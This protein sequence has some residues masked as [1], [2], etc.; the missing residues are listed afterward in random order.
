[1]E[2]PT[3]SSAAPDDGGVRI[4][5]VGG[6][7]G[8]HITPGLEVVERLTQDGR[9]ASLTWLAGDRRVDRR[10]LDALPERLAPIPVRVES[11]GVEG[12]RDAAPSRGAQLR[13]LPRAVA[14]ARAVL[15][16]S[17]AELLIALGGYT[18]LPAALA[19]RSLGIPL[20]LVEVNSV[21]GGATKLLSPLAA[22]VCH[23]FDASVPGGSRTDDP[24]HRADTR[25]GVVGPIVRTRTEAECRSIEARA[26]ELLSKH[27]LAQ[28]APLL[29]VLGGSQGA[30]AL[31][32]FVREQI[33]LFRDC[34]LQVLH[35]VGPGRM[36]EAA[37]DREGYAAVEFLDPVDPALSAAT[38]VLSRAGAA[39]L[40]ELIA[41]RVPAILVPYPHAAGDHQAHNAAQVADGAVVIKE[42]LLDRERAEGIAML[43]GESGVDRRRR[44]ALELARHS[45]LDGAGEVARSALEL[46]DRDPESGPVRTPE[47]VPSRLEVV[48]SELEGD[49]LPS[50]LPNRVHLLG[51]GG[52]GMSGLARLLVARGLD[53]SGH[54][55]AESERLIDLRASSIKIDSGAGATLPNDAELVVRSAA[56][57]DSDP[58]VVEA[59]ERGLAVIKYAAA[60]G[61]ITPEGRT[62]A[63]A[64]THGKTSTSWLLMHAL[65]G[66]T[67]DSR[68]E[69]RPGALIG[70]ECLEL[71]TNAVAP[72]H[73]GP[74]VV[75]ACEY[76]RSFLELTPRIAIITNVEADH[77]DCFG[78]FDG[79]VRAFSEF[80][81]RVDSD[82]LL[83]LGPDVPA[84]I[85][86]A[87]SC[88]VLRHGRDLRPTVTGHEA[89]RYRF[90]LEG[91]GY[92]VRA[93]ELEV[94]GRFQVD[95]ATL[96][97]AAA[98]ELLGADR[99]QRIAAGLSNYRG[100]G[101]R[102]EYWFE[103][104]PTLVVHDYAH[105]PTELRVTLQAAREVFAGKALHV[106]FQPHQ[107]ERTARFLDDFAASLAVADRVV[108]A[109]V[110]GARA[111]DRD[112]PAASAE[113]LV[114]RLEAL[115]ARAIHG[116]SLDASVSAVL[117]ELP[118]ET[119]L[120]VVGAG[121][122]ET[123]RDDLVRRVA[124]RR[125][126][127]S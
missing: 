34:G 60:L 85:E 25:H 83:V 55:R 31:N 43:A 123:I 75:E 84:A 1:M 96:V 35:Q 48:P 50:G 52:A 87:A 77:L 97:V 72:G 114:A 47:V 101:R 92:T 18:T 4:A 112:A 57:P 126:S 36:D 11:L 2:Q 15:N 22:R 127:P 9:L 61:R 63:V 89:G 41:F 28:D 53:P 124:L 74:F 46:L 122:V 86:A 19:A 71:G 37:S 108:V 115:G 44:M 5:V 106:L 17:R 64:G 42:S 88:R 95:N 13:R 20:L 125:G 113:D 90:D 104:G 16:E 94:P 66:A 39:T 26:A 59:R 6:G 62:L 21:L 3:H 45:E 99:A 40:A 10:L 68:G 109:D 121:D 100:S 23:A 81:A 78:D 7:T 110:Y 117:D 105:H 29:L 118:D 119:A 33:D 32:R 56:V 8:G 51:V 79:V 116:G 76:D 111:A 67:S 93:I 107:Y 30:G 73:E 27:G 70:G 38:L 82:G 12:G 80:A 65:R 69:D 54:D 14:R 58:Q 103:T 98:V 120:L 24:R 49:A 91:P 102:F